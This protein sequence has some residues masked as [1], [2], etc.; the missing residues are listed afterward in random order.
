[1]LDQLKCD[2]NAILKNVLLQLNN[3]KKRF[4]ICVNESDHIVGVVSD[5]DIRQAFL[6]KLNVTDTIDKVYN[7]DFKCLCTD[8]SFSE[9]CELFRLDKIDFL[10]VVNQDKKLVNVLT[11]KQFHIALLENIDFDLESDF[12]QL[13]DITLEHEIYNRP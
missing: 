8:S 10:P 1:M 13:D 4:V 11:K 12:T 3:N 5:S 2:Q 6:K 9:I 7:A